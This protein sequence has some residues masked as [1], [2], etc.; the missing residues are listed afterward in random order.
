MN[1]SLSY[2]I[3]G[4]IALGIFGLFAKVVNDPVGFLR[5]IIVMI[6]IACAIFFIYRMI[7]QDKH[8]NAGQRAFKKAAR[9][10]KK[11]TKSKSNITSFSKAANS[12]KKNRIRKKSDIHLTVIEGKKNKKKNRAHF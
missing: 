2:I 1:R 3:Y 9:K 11:R 8:G 4:I 10:T 12:T 6:V 5:N 7:T